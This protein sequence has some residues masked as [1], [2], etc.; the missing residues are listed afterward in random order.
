MHFRKIFEFLRVN[1]WHV[2][3]LGAEFDEAPL[4]PLEPVADISGFAA[5]RCELSSSRALG[6]SCCSRRRA[7]TAVGRDWG[8]V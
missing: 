4:L 5:V 1:P 7:G 2:K 6:Q 3:S 8:C